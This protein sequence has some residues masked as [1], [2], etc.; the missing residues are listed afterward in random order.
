MQQDMASLQQNLTAEKTRTERLELRLA[1]LLRNRFGR[2]S[3][4][5]GSSDQLDLLIEDTE[6]AL[7]QIS[8]SSNVS[9]TP[10]STSRSRKRFSESLPREE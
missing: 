8:P 10:P 7:A 5:S 1:A 6:T 4:R 3:E 9:A 2:S